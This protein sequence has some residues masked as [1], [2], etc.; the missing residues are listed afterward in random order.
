MFHW[1]G[2]RQDFEKLT[3]TL[4]PMA[5]KVEAH[6]TK[7]RSMTGWCG[8][9]EEITELQSHEPPDG[10]WLDLRENILCRCGL[11]GRMRSTYAALCEV[12]D[13]R[14]PGQLLMLERVTPLF[15][16]VQER[17]PFAEGCEYLG[18]DLR[19][20][21]IHTVGNL[22]V[23]HEDLLNLSFPDETFDVLFHGD[24]LE[25]VPNYLTAFAECRRVLRP[26]G[27]M[28][29]TCPFFDLDQHLLRCQLVDGELRHL[30]PPTYHRNPLS[31]AGSLVFAEYGWPLLQ[32]VR[33]AGFSEVSIGF[34]YD[35]FQ[36][37]VSNNNPY[38]EGHMWPVIF[39]A[40]R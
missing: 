8:V 22:S 15:Q 18:A 36:G 25:H 1:V 5:A 23:R 7:T 16:K 13:G 3:Q 19:S 37:I 40:V 38:R 27:V 31:N 34:L 33:D 29:F 39:K 26:G 17:Y 28:V 24:V 11:N 30:R 21:S 35:A 32:D 20:G 10:G 6:L 12:L 9:C 2:N 4:K 14:P